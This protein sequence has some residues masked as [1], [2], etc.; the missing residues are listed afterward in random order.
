MEGKKCTI[1]GQGESRRNFIHAYDTAQAV[2]TIMLK[3]VLGE[4]YNIGTNNEF[5]VNDIYTILMKKLK[6][7]ESLDDWR[8]TV[9]D[10]NF[11]DQR[12]FVDSSKL[13]Q[14]GWKETIPFDEGLDKTIEWYKENYRLYEEVK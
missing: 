10:R 9:P 3:G 8:I 11:N 1:H 5:S 7:D 2:K 6:P 12:Y 14:L 4:T 13:R